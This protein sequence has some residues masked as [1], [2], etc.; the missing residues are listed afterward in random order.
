MSAGSNLAQQEAERRREGVELRTEL[1]MPS[2]DRQPKG[3]E[4][5]AE[6]HSRVYALEPN[7]HQFENGIRKI[8][9]NRTYEATPDHRG[10]VA[11]V[12]GYT[13]MNFYLGE[14]H[15]LLAVGRFTRERDGSRARELMQPTEQLQRLLT[16]HLSVLRGR[17]G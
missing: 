11:V 12:G 4:R 17:A 8:I 14:S 13:Q 15:Q 5:H 7:R 6:I 1:R 3:I 9:V 2:V 16:S 10:R